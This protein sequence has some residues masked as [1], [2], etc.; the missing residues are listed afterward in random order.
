M[1]DHSLG[2][3]LYALRAA[4]AAGE[5]VERERKWQDGQ[6]PRGIRRLVLSA[7]RRGGI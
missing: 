2:A 7:R 1:A 4:K 6:L 3:A 5:P